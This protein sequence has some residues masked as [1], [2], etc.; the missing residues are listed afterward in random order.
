M[1]RSDGCL[2]GT[3]TGAVQGALLYQSVQIVGWKC[4]TRSFQTCCTRPLGRSMPLSFS[5]QPCVHS[6]SSLFY[7]V[8]TILA[9][10]AT[11]LSNYIKI[12]LIM[13]LEAQV[14]PFIVPNNPDLCMDTVQFGGAVLCLIAPIWW[15]SNRLLEKVLQNRRH[16]WSSSWTLLMALLS[17]CISHHFARQWHL[18]MA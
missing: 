14:T 4:F 3:H 6:M 9:N 7:H 16:H 10:P 5:W 12:C 8:I 2:S 13:A 17:A 11:W 15:V 1:V 18:N